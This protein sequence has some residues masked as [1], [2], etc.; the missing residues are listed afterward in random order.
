MPQ[1]NVTIVVNGR[2]H[3]VARDDISFEE[4]ISLAFDPLPS[5]DNIVFTVTY[6]RGHGNKPAGTL[7]AGESVRV[8]DGM[9]F[10]VTV[11]DKS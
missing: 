5:G 9:I 3:E 10:D 11:T 6:R 1:P 2:S 7:V 8:K 4:V